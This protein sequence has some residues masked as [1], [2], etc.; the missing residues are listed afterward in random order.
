MRM[1]RLSKG[2]DQTRIERL[3]LVPCPEDAERA[4]VSAIRARFGELLR[5]SETSWMVLLPD[6]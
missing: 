4:A 3:P 1:E 2:Q 6:C 5:D